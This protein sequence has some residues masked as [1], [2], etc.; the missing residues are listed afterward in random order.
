MWFVEL[1]DEEVQSKDMAAAAQYA[2]NNPII[3]I[4]DGSTVREVQAKEHLNFK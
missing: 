3:V 1:A 4:K 2:R